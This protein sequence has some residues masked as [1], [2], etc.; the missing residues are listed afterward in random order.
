VKNYPSSEKN[1]KMLICIEID[2]KISY[3]TSKRYK[4]LNFIKKK[5]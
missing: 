2:P 5:M 3:L 4:V 1:V